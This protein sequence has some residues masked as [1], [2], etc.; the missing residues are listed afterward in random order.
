MTNVTP[1]QVQA[2][3][4][5]LTDKGR[6]TMLAVGQGRLSFFD[7]GIVENSGIWGECLTGELGHKSSGVVNRLARLGLWNVTHDL[8]S[9]DGAWWDLTALGAAVANTLADEAAAPKEAEVE[10]TE[11]GVFEMGHGRTNAIRYQGTARTADGA[12]FVCPHNASAGHTSGHRTSEA[13]DRCIRKE[14]AASVK[15]AQETEILPPVD[16]AT[17]G[18]AERKHVYRDPA[19]ALANFRALADAC[20]RAGNATS[21]R[22]WNAKASQLRQAMNLAANA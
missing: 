15:P 11:Y 13:A 14:M 6:A 20:Q 2:I 1:A 17:P 7:D 19:A 10:T 16:T 22:F 3:I 4:A 8:A 9:D 5:Q 12:E 21:F 18:T